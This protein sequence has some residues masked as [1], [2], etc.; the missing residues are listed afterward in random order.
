MAARRVP[1]GVSPSWMNRQVRPPIDM[2]TGAPKALAAGRARQPVARVLAD[3][4]GDLEWL[5]SGVEDQLGPDAT[6]RTVVA[7]GPAK[8]S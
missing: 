8:C 2:R 5:R 3:R 1:T 4:L 6:S 7:V